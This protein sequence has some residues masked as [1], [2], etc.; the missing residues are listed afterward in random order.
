MVCIGTAVVV[1]KVSQICVLTFAQTVPTCQLIITSLPYCI[2]ADL[3]A[4]HHHHLPVP[5]A[6]V[7]F[8]AALCF[9]SIMATSTSDGMV[10]MKLELSPRTFR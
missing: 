1:H 8:C 9:C 2:M 7:F 3:S 5:V 4:A 6:C 10:V